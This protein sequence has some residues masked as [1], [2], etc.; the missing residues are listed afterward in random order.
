MKTIQAYCFAYELREEQY[1]RV[2][3]L[4]DKMNIKFH[5][6][7]GV[8]G[9]LHRFFNSV[10]SYSPSEHWLYGFCGKHHIILKKQE[11]LEAIRRANG[12]KSIIN[13]Y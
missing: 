11:T 3:F 8:P 1:L 13:N 2:Y 7:N 12:K 10:S 6:H 4:L 9:S 5:D